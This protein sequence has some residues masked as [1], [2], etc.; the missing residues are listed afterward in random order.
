MADEAA[1]PAPPVAED[2]AEPAPP[3]ALDA[4]EPA[5]PVAEEAAEPAP[6]V[7]EPPPDVAAPAAPAKSVVEPVVVVKV[8]PSVVMTPTSAEVPVALELWPSPPLP[9]E[10]PDPPDALE[11]IWPA[12]LVGVEPP[13]AVEVYCC[14]AL[15]Q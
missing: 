4:A 9:A 3:V 14:R 7:N 1:E 10:D 5:P 2:A 8:E 11:R 12:E 13:L 6:E 15:A